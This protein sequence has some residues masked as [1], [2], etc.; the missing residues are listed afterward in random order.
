MAQHAGNDVLKITENL[1][2]G[3]ALEVCHADA[4]N[5][6][7]H[8]RSHNAEDRGDL[9][10]EER[11]ECVAFEDI[12]SDRLDER[13]QERLT[14]KKGKKTG[15]RRRAVGKQQRQAEQAVCLLT[16]LRHADRDEG[17]DDQRNHEGQESGEQRGERREQP[18]DR[19][20]SRRIRNAEPASAKADQHTGDDAD[21]ESNQQSKL[22]QCYILLFFIFSLSQR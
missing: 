2:H 4:E 17:N 13:R 15:D 11:L 19:N 8:E 22:F 14:D 7:K 21:N 16:Q 10:G 3:I 18:N 6:C 9:D 20:K 5:E 12:A 1:E